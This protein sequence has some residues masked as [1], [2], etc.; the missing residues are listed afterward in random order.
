MNSKTNA[1][2]SFEKQLLQEDN[3]V[4]YRYLRK[5]PWFM[6]FAL[7]GIVLGFAKYKTTP[8]T[9]EVS[10]KILIKGDNN[11]LRSNISMDNILGGASNSNISNQLEILQS[12]TN[13]KKA[14]TNLNWQTSWFRPGKPFDKEM[15]NY[16]PAEVAI[17]IDAENLTSA[18][19]YI[20]ILDD[21]NFRVNVETETIINGEEQVLN[22][23]QNGTFGKPF[24]NEYYNFILY[25]TPNGRKG[26]YYFRFNNY[27][28]LAQSLLKRVQVDVTNTNSDV[29]KMVLVG[30][31]PQKEA[32]FLNEL[33]R[34]FIQLGMDE[35][36][37]SAETSVTF[38]SDQLGKIKDSLDRSEEAFTDYRRKNQVVDLSQEANFIYQRLEEIESE[39]YEANMRLNYYQNLK[40]Y[41]DDSERIKQISSPSMVG[42][43]DNN[44]TNMLQKL[45]ELYNRRELLKYS[46]KEKS[47]S[48]VL[49]EREISL[50]TNSLEENL[51]NLISNTK[52]EVSGIE[53]RNREIQARL[54]QLP[55]TEKELIGI[56]REFE[57]N[58]TMYNYMLK[59]KAEAEL[60]QAST[61]PKVQIIDKAMPE[62]AILTGPDMKKY[63]AIGLVLGLI[64]PFLIIY[65][66]DAFSS[67][68]RTSE[69]VENLT[70]V[71][72]LDGIILAKKNQKLPVIKNPRSGLAESFRGLRYSIKKMLPEDDHSVI[73]INSMVPGEGKSF[74]ASNLAAI[75]AM[76]DKK[77]LLVGADI[78]RPKLEELFGDNKGKGLST[79]LA[80]DQIFDE[81]VME[82]ETE[83]LFFVPAGEIMPNPTELL[84]NGRIETFLS[85]AKKRFDYIILDNA[86]F[87]MVSDSMTTSSLANISLYLVRINKTNRKSIKEIEKVIELNNIKNAA[88][89]INGTNVSGLSKG[90]VKKGYGVYSK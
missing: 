6:A 2:Y 41:L 85:E 3:E 38:I 54:Q 53:K 65:L 58:N 59:K 77:V 80:S 78:R 42:I 69:E 88:I 71:K 39:K 50:I 31:N 63:V 19:I 23:E 62:S 87:S 46:V 60:S 15:Y 47:P 84:E 33:N 44:L 1:P 29:I 26:T 72:V 10:S 7:I 27:N 30:T 35:E 45:S 81:V 43:D 20:T 55:K 25:K 9:F 16:E 11:P 89:V 83:N 82:T 64:I 86:P 12:F 70:D 22:I 76:N 56:Q 51:N 67:S 32:D 17:P 14:L 49:V 90:Y 24:V 74:V 66:L 40:D 18:D 36:E 28:R 52:S 75:F 61:A 79:Y 68:I 48:Y 21:E 8:Q 73:S 4:F 5:W 37:R 57:L 34:V 13:Y